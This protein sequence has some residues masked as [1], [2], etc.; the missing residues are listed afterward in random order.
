MITKETVFF[1]D[2]DGTLV[3]TNEANLQAYKK[4]V[5]EVTNLDVNS[6]KRFTRSSL[7]E[8]IPN[9]KD[10]EQ[11][12]IINKKEEYFSE[13]LPLTILNKPI[14]DILERYHQSNTTVLVTNCRQGRAMQILDYHNMAHM[15]SHLLFRKF[16]ENSTKVNKFDNAITELGLKPYI[17]IAFED[18]ESEIVDAKLTGIQIIN[19][20]NLN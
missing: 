12:L 7:M 10:E 8:C 15:F 13:F 6:K 4:A 19:P 14:Y 5:K 20:K 18:E 9:L 16:I 1:F 2:L 3:D 17:I 11:D